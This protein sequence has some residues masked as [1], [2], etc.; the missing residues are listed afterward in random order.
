MNHSNNLTPDTNS[1]NS[2]II[3]FVAIKKNLKKKKERKR[4]RVSCELQQRA[5][6]HKLV[7]PKERQGKNRLK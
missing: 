1:S 2:W 4:K 7:L 3:S 5:D 6:K